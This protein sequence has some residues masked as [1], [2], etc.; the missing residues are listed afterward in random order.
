[1]AL[2]SGKR[3]PVSGCLPLAS[4]ASRLLYTLALA[5]GPRQGLPRPTKCCGALQKHPQVPQKTTQPH[6]RTQRL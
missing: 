2:P 1:M 4:L 5:G 6:F 3:T